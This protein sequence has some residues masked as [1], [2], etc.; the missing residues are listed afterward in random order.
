VGPPTEHAAA[1]KKPP[2]KHRTKGR[3]RWKLIGG[4]RRSYREPWPGQETIQ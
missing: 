3:L 1:A 4:E 2:K